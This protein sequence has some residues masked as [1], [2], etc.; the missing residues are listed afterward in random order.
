MREQRPEELHP[1]GS[2]VGN[3]ERELR[4]TRVLLA[5]AWG[6]V[7]H[8]QAQRLLGFDDP[9]ILRSY[10]ERE[11]ERIDAQ[12]RFWWDRYRDVGEIV[13]EAANATPTGLREEGA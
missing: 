8:G 9:L 13:A 10:L 7:S 12:A 5:L 1:A 11:T 4:R 2:Y 3:L 6:L